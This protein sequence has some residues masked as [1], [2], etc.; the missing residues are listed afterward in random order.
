MKWKYSKQSNVKQHK[1]IKSVKY[2]IIYEGKSI[3]KDKKISQSPLLENVIYEKDMV[4]IKGYW[5]ITPDKMH[6][7]PE[8]VH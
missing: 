5:T 6:I 3:L 4:G 7:S 2:V 1:Q 8:T